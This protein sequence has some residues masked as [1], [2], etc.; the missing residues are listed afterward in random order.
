ML[1]YLRF[2]VNPD[3]ILAFERIVNTPTRGIGPIAI[4]GFQ[5]WASNVRKEGYP[6][7][8]VDDLKDVVMTKESTEIASTNL[9]SVST[10]CGKFDSFYV[11]HK[12]SRNCVSSDF[13]KSLLGHASQLHPSCTLNSHGPKLSDIMVINQHLEGNGMKC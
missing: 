10:F 11:W 13:L 12:Y 4:E 2:L 1:C 9:L 7:A 5:D 8:L 6:G 3:D